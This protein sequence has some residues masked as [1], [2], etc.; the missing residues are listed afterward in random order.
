MDFQKQTLYTYD[1]E[2][3]ILHIYSAKIEGGVKGCISIGDYN[4]DIGQDNS[5]VGIEIEQASKLLQIDEN[6]LNDLDEVK[7]IVRKAGNLL[8]IGFIT[9]KNKKES[10]IQFSIPYNK[11]QINLTN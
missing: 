1:S 9:I 8:F 6:N 4:I 3:D 7:L 11:A 5:V 2:L 10:M